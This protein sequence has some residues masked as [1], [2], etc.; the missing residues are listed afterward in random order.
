MKLKTL[1]EPLNKVEA[2]NSESGFIW[3]IFEQNK[4]VNIYINGFVDSRRPL[5]GGMA[6]HWC[7][8]SRAQAV[9]RTGST[10]I[11]ALLSF[12]MFSTSYRRT[13]VEE[14]EQN[15]KK[16]IYLFPGHTC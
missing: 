4:Q 16:M 1:K 15:V 12:S 9:W 6:A 11:S 10:K 3:R 13:G 8:M 7:L 5:P 14:H 2:K